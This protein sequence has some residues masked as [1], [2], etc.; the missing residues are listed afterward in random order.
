MLEVTQTYRLFLVLSLDAAETG[1]VQSGTGAE[2][3][4]KWSDIHGHI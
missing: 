1:A 2:S 4:T 3:P